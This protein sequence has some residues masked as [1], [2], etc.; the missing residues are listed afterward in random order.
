MRPHSRMLLAVAVAS[1]IAL[2]LFRPVAEA[3]PVT[4]P[5]APLAVVALGEAVRT[6]FA[7]VHWA[8]GN[9]LSRSDARLASEQGG[10]VSRVVEVGEHVRKGQVLAQLEDGALRLRESEEQARLA[11]IQTQRDLNLRQL[12]RLEQLAE[13]GALSASQLDAA[14]GELAMLAHEADAARLA[15]RQIRLRIEQA[16][17]R[18]PFAGVVAERFAQLG[19]HVGA[20]VA[21]LRLVDTQ[22]T[23]LRVHAP[24]SMAARLAPGTEVALSGDSAP[25]QGRITAVVPV[26]DEPSRQLEL[27]IGLGD[28]RLPVGAALQAGLPVGTPRSVLAVPQDALLMRREGNFVF[29]IDADDTAQRV[30]I[31]TGEQFDSLIE[32]RG[33]IAPGDRLVIRGGERLQPGQR[34]MPETGPVLNAVVAR[35]F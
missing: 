23:E 32:V 6:E 31:E 34:V 25:T 19:E 5:A 33:D 8:P 16:R 7:P 15:L 12:D 24:V 20:G 21:L 10:I 17:L 13:R 4:A 27:R 1:A 30:A 22:A 11:R 14:R 18:A 3:Q 35:R 26:G 28:A 9:V 29:R 2:P